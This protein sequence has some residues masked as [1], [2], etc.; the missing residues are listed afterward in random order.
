MG[1]GDLG[2]TLGDWLNRIRGLE[3]SYHHDVH[4]GE[5]GPDL[6]ENADVGAVD[7]L[8]LEELEV[9]YVGVVALELAHVFDFLQLGEDEAVVGVAFAVN[10]GQDGVAIFPAVLAGKPAGRLGEKEEHQTE[11]N[12]WKHLQA[13]WDAE[14]GGTVDV[15]TAVGNVEHDQLGRC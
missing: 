9:R 2:G 6:G 11:E 1:I 14:G 10:E 8:G 7:H 15:R 4:A 3:G 13:P 5:L 12:G